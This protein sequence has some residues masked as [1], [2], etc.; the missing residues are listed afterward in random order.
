MNSYRDFLQGK[1]A[2][3]FHDGIPVDRSSL[4]PRLFDFQKDIVDLSLRRGRSAIFADTGLGKGWMALEWLRHVSMHTDAPVLL[5]APLAVSQQFVREGSLFGVPVRAC[6]SSSDVCEG[7]NVANYEK[8]HKF[9]PSDFG[10]VALDESSILKAYDGR[11]RTA[12]IEAFRDTPFRLSLT[13]TPSPNDHTELGNQAEFLGVMTRSEMLSMFFVHDGETTQEWRLKG[14]AKEP[15]WKWVASWAVA[16]GRPSDLGYDD[17]AYDLPP[18]R[19][20]VHTVRAPQPTGTLF[21]EM[22]QGLS[23]VR[24][25]RKATID[26][27]VARCVDLANS[28]A[29]PVLIWCD[30]NAEGD[31]LE[32]S[33]PGAVQVTGSQDDEMKE[34]LL[35]DFAEGRARVLVTKPSIAGF[36][37]NWQHCADMIFCG[38][39]HSWESYYQ[40]IRRC[41]RFGQDREV[42]VYVVVSDADAGVIASL[43]R[44]QIDANVMKESMTKIMSTHTRSF[45]Q[46]TQRTS[47]PYV[48]TVAISFPSWIQE[49]A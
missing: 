37:L 35:T 13:A 40:S 34:R 19:E 42:N 2:R 23:D 47:D 14:H 16:I 18:L 38:V 3:S 22:T 46:S 33:I 27:R 8:L 28:I 44:K 36:G 7:I 9:D 21:A 1:A 45:I 5:L 20:T 4:S 24:N 15:F 29:R 30:F 6:S 41:W 39:T 26:D 11:T 49:N 25:A 12:I 31:A 17:G 43:R 10:G 48:A 32:A